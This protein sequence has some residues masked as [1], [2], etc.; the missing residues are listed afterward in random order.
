MKRHLYM[1]RLDQLTAE[2][3][4]QAPAAAQPRRVVAPAPEQDQREAPRESGRRL[5]TLVRPGRYGK[6]TEEIR[7]AADD[8]Q[9]H[10]FLSVRIWTEGRYGNF[11]PSQR[12]ITVRRAEVADFIK[13]MIAGA[14]ELGVE[15]DLD[16]ET[17][18]DHA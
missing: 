9:G 15:L 14:R 7:I 13:A 6:P 4:A 12:G 5:G 18:G 16:D 3:P 1:E 11:Y 2:R 8:Y 10:D 17:G